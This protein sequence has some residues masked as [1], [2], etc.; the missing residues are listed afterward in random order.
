MGPIRRVLNWESVLIFCDAFRSCHPPFL[1]VSLGCRFSVYSPLIVLPYLVFL[2]S[3]AFASSSSTPLPLALLQP[4]T[5][6]LCLLPFP[7]L[8]FDLH[9][10]LHGGRRVQPVHEHL[11]ERGGGREHPRALGQGVLLQHEAE[12][13]L[14]L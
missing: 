13:R 12:R 11:S 8:C 2:L 5:E 6:R 1:V 10:E 3:L 4:N 14:D 7:L 9:A